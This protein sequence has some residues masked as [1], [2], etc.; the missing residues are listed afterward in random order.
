MLNSKH[1]AVNSLDFSQAETYNCV[2]DPTDYDRT[3]LLDPDI[4]DIGTPT[5]KARR[6]YDPFYVLTAIVL[7]GESDTSFPSNHTK[8]ASVNNVERTTIY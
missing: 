1:S 4:V 8:V 7:P 5:G 6:T 2:N 3:H